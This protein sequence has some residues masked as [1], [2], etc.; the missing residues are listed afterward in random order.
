MRL[1]YKLIFV[2]EKQRKDYK[3]HKKLGSKQI[4]RNGPILPNLIKISS[5]L[6]FEMFELD[7]LYYQAKG[8]KHVYTMF[9]VVNVLMIRYKILLRFIVR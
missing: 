5:P 3:I 7:F 8:K 6:L 1:F 4:K 9:F 2:F